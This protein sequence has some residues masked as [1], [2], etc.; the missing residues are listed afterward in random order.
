[1]LIR[2]FLM[3]AS[4]VLIPACAVLDDGQEARPD[5]LATEFAPKVSTQALGVAGYSAA[6]LDRTTEEER[7]GALGPS[8]GAGGE[9]LG[10]AVVALGPPA[11]AG[12]WVQSALVTAPRKGRIVAP[13]GQ[14]LAVELRP[15]AGA[16]RMSLAAYRAL[17]IGLT[18]L[19]EVTVYGL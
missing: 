14:A 7:R 3:M 18:E 6:A 2:A 8:A 9:R 19:P 11:D 16:A 13:G 1:M 5:D 15:G 17:G 12:L 10:S 4:C